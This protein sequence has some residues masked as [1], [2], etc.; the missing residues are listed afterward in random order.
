MADMVMLVPS[1]S[2]PANVARLA[3]AMADTC[4]AGTQLLVLVDQDDP[5]LAEYGALGVD[6]FV[7]PP[8]DL[9]GMTIPLNRA[10]IL[11]AREYDL[12]GFLGD[13]VL[14]RTVGWDQRFIDELTKLETGIVWGDDLLQHDIWPTH[15]SMTADIIRALGWMAMPALTHLFVDVVWMRLGEKLDR[16][17]YLPDVILEHMHPAA[18]KATMDDLYTEINSPTTITHDG[19]AYEHWLANTIDADITRI[20][21]SCNLP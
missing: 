20:R 18:A 4:T 15:V 1:R 12:V 14:P 7:A 3:Q 10:A 13:D 8:G 5:T 2:R 11:A 16:I 9:R 21:D 6:L 17:R 19:A